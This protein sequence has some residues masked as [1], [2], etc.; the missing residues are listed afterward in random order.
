VD[1]VYWVLSH[2]SSYGLAAP[3]KLPVPMAGPRMGYPCPC[4]VWTTWARRHWRSP[5]FRP[6]TTLLL[7]LECLLPDCRGRIFTQQQFY[8]SWSTCLHYSENPATSPDD[9]TTVKIKSKC[10]EAAQA[11]W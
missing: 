6:A 5:F 8:G 7:K 3:S 10:F 11:V 9:C 2:A 4:R 1:A